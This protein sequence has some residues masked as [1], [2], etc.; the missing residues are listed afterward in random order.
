L[1]KI[2]RLKERKRRLSKKE[3]G[4]REELETVRNQ[5]ALYFTLL[6]DIGRN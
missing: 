5:V 1:A 3:K 2:R 4:S 6:K